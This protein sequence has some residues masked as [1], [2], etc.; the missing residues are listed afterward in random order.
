[1]NERNEEE[2]Q[3]GVK[4]KFLVSELS[5]IVRAAFTRNSSPDAFPQFI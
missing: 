3:Q 1:M 4:K 5:G 2:M